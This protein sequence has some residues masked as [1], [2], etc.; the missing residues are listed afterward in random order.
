MQIN[1]ESCA[2]GHWYERTDKLSSN[3]EPIDEV[4]VGYV[5]YTF[6]PTF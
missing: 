5:V 3:Q 1:L 4:S 6:H 2:V